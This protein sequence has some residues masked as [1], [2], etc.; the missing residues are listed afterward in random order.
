GLDNIYLAVHD[1]D[2]KRFDDGILR[3][4]EST[5]T[6]SIQKKIGQD[7]ETGQHLI[8]STNDL[9]INLDN[10]LANPGCSYQHTVGGYD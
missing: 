5:K 8:V 2:N 6:L 10:I 4:G 9:P 7:Q 3:S 1:G